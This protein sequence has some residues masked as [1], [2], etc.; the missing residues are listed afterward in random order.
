V[1]K[2]VEG[3]PISPH[4]IKMMGYIEALTVTPSFKA[5]PNA[6]SMRPQ[7]SSLHT[8]RIENGHGITNVLIKYIYYA[9]NVLHK[10]KSN[11]LDNI[12]VERLH[13]STSNRSRV[14]AHLELFIK[15]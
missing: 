8:Y 11:I 4:V 5:K 2:L 9:N 1:C 6:H 3:S 7:K 13:N 14:I 12:V 10:T 15:E